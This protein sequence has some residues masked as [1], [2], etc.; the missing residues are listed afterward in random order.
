[1]LYEYYK[2]KY[3]YIKSMILNDQIIIDSL[4]KANELHVEIFR[5]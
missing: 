4:Q 2:Y 5:N 1:M 3:D